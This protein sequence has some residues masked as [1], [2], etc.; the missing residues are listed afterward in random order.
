MNKIDIKEKVNNIIWNMIG[1]MFATGWI[2]LPILYG[3]FK[4]SDVGFLLS[5]VI[6]LLILFIFSSIGE[7][8]KIKESIQ[9]EY[10]SLEVEKQKLN[11]MYILKEENLEK[12][13]KSIFENLQKENNKLS[14]ILNDKKIYKPYLATI[15]SDYQASIDSMKE[16]ALLYKNNPSIK[17]AEEVKKIKKINK[18]LLKELKTT[19]YQLIVYEN[20]FPWLEEFKEIPEEKIDIIMSD[21]EL[22][23]Y[24]KAKEFVSPIE[25][26]QLDE[27]ERYQVWLN[28]YRN[29]PDKTNWQIGID[30]ERY[31]G[32][33]Y[34][35][36][37]YKIIY[38]GAR[39]GLE[40]LGRDLIATKG[41]EVLVIQCKN[42]SKSKIIHEKHIFQ[43]Y[44]TVVLK[45]IEESNKKVKGIFIC[46]NELSETAK[47]VAK[48][49]NIKVIENYK[50]DRTYPCIKC[51]ISKKDGSKIFHLP[52][53]QQYDRVDIETKKGEKYVS[54]VKEAY[55]LGFRKAMRHHY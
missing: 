40:D 33:K 17:G 52:F 1:Y 7:L 43:L 9:Q 25:W 24:E 47:E 31:V 19:K 55:E 34:E 14:N 11:D 21:D 2:V 46:T 50:Y 18:E 6:Y 48:Y 32:Y 35:M 51:N 53:D 20:L 45:S 54:S 16:E 12:N 8:K 42:W 26:R 30:F 23:D 36:N 38:N 10:K 28:K 44:G 41:E 22:D 4:N 39:K 49:L 15:L 37:G 29:N 27:I 3:G 5:F 13:Y